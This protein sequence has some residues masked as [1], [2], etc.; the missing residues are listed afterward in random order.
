VFDA[1]GISWSYMM[2]F[3]MMAS[4]PIMIMFA[5]VQKWFVAGL[6]AGAVKG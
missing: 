2:A 5:V 1:V 3:A 6:T 4:L